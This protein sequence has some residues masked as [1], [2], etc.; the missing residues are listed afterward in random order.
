VVPIAST[1]SSFLPKKK[2]SQALRIANS[3]N[4]VKAKTA[5]AAIEK[6]TLEGI[7]WYQ[8]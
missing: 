7:R 1:W 3:M 6:S 2:G 5:A 8:A 4:T